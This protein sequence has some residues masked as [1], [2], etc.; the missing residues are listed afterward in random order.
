MIEHNLDLDVIKIDLEQLLLSLKDIAKKEFENT[1]KDVSYK[2]HQNDFVTQTDILLNSILIAHL[3]KNYPSISIISEESDTISKHST[4]S[5]VI[6]P[7]DGTRNFVRQIPQFYIGIGL[8]KENKTILCLTYNPILDELF[9]AIHTKGAFVNNTP[10]TI[11][12]RELQDSDII[13]RLGYKNEEKQAILTSQLL[14]KICH[15]KNTGSTHDELAGVAY[16]RYDGFISKG[17][18]P[19][20]NCQYLLVEEAG[21][22]VTDFNGDDFNV[23]TEHIVASNKTIHSQLLHYTKDLN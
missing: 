11:E 22:K 13:V 23:F 1:H 21:G 16:N 14:P 7:I 15:I 3:E 4:Y 10:I 17:S 12:N 9:H 18:S 2:S 5:F 20:D 19:W 6:D 8:I